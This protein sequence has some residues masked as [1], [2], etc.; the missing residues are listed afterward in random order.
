MNNVFKIIVLTS[1]LLLASCSEKEIVLYRDSE[2]VQDS[3]VSIKID[4]I[5][6]RDIF[7]S[8][9]Q[10]IYITFVSSNPKPVALKFK[11]WKIYREKDDAEYS[12]GCIT[13]A[14]GG[15]LKLECEV[16]KKVYFSASLPSS[17]KEEKY[18]LVTHF[19][20]KTLVCHLYDYLEQS[21]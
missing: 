9:S 6:E 14:F 19:D 21:N 8:Y 12:A 7:S 5:F 3:D 16:E 2:P 13:L 11:D 20:S 17:I 10:D 1:T 18:K 15:E 4:S